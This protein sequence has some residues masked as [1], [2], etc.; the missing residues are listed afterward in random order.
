MLSCENTAAKRQ[1]TVSTQLIGASLGEP[2]TS[3]V[4]GN[5]YID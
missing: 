2:Y 1:A 5:K 4:Y 3:V